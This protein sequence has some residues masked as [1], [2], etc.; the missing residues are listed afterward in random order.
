MALIIT[1]D[2]KALPHYE[3]ADAPAGYGAVADAMILPVMKRSKENAKVTSARTK[4]YGYKIQACLAY[5][6]TKGSPEQITASYTAAF[7]K[8]ASL[9][10]KWVVVSLE[11]YR[12]TKISPDT[13]YCAISSAYASLGGND[14]TVFVYSREAVRAQYTKEELNEFWDKRYVVGEDYKDELDEYAKEAL[15]RE[16]ANIELAPRAES[17]EM[18]YSK[19]STQGRPKLRSADTEPEKLQTREASE[20]EA[21]E[22]AEYERLIGEPAEEGPEE[23]EAEEETEAGAE[24][25]PEDIHSILEELKAEEGKEGPEAAGRRARLQRKIYAERS[26]MK[27]CLEIPR[28]DAYKRAGVK[29]EQDVSYDAAPVCGKP[30]APADGDLGGYIKDRKQKA[31]TFSQML[32]RLIDEK[33]MTD[34]QCYTKANIDR[35]HFSKIRSDDSYKPTKPTVFAFAIALGLN[36]AD[37][38]KLLASAGYAI[39]Y[40]SVSDIIIEFFIDRHIYDIN[41]INAALFDYDQPLL[42][43]QVSA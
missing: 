5:R 11:A 25:L 4:R 38:R 24:E 9:G 13:A 37:T 27:Q 10:C 19:E 31:E 14:L 32:F 43:V 3:Y 18:I 40:N 22:A 28:R 33:G 23:E 20:A 42:G 21:A 8:A 30:A 34:V 2:I 35:R 17:S 39:T 7:G 12:D 29:Y 26:A 1:K 15:E 41:L 16:L 36:I 6:K